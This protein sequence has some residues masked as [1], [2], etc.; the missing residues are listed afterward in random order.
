HER[1]PLI[2]SRHGGEYE[3]TCCICTDIYTDPVTLTCGHS[4]CRICINKTLDR[5]EEREYSCPVCRHRFRPQQESPEHVLAEPTTFFGSR[6]C[7]VHKKT[8][9]YY[10]YEEAA[11][12]CSSCMSEKCHK[13]HRV[14]K[15]SDATE[16]KNENLR[17]VLEMLIL[18]RKESDK[19]V[20]SLEELRR[21][22]QEKAAGVTERVTALIRDIREQLEALEKRVLSEISRQEEQVSLRV[23]DLI[24][25][26]EI[27]KEELS[28]KI[29]HV[30]EQLSMMV[31]PLAG[32]QR[33]ECDVAYHCDTVEVGNEDNDGDIVEDLDM[34]LITAIFHSSIS[35]IVNGV[36]R[37][38]HVLGASD[39]P[40]GIR[41]VSDIS[42][43]I[44][45]AGNNLTISDDLKTLSWSELSLS[46]Q[47]T[48]ERFQYSQ[49]LSSRSFSLGRHYWEVEVSDSGSWSVGMAYPRIDRKGSHSG[50]GYNNMSWGLSKWNNSYRAMHGSKGIGLPHLPSCQRFGIYLDYEAGRLSFYELCDPIRH[51][52]T[53]TATFT[54]PIHACF[55]VFG[56]S[57]SSDTELQKISSYVRII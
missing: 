19:R 17:N 4:F 38:Q 54:E 29:G 9:I 32:L 14:E 30:E 15:L 42:L 3:L 33:Q 36:I 7:P 28:R 21:Q 43:D 31:D 39:L 53:F 51:L 27:K 1:Q 6:K 16:K 37:W 2:Y 13:G 52:H 49:V 25:Q 45:T 47:E 50:I 24:R 55:W 11:C 56:G 48:S 23:S 46:W 57:T 10:C 35:N 40:F 5:Q 18:D 20:Q 26:L 41:T 34:G 44:N 22:V 8:L 12:I